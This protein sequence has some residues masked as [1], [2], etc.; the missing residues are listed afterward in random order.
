M[1]CFSTNPFH[2]LYLSP[3]FMSTMNHEWA[4]TTITSHVAGSKDIE[5]SP[6]TIMVHILAT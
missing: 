5:L 2:N 3:N 4:S 6:L 1:D